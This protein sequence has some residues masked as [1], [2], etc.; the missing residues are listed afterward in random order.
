MSEAETSF[1]DITN[2]AKYAPLAF[3]PTTNNAVD[4]LCLDFMR[5][6]SDED[7]QIWDNCDIS[8]RNETTSGPVLANTED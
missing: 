3:S 7:E 4:N 8:E 1:D 2:L 5:S 6:M